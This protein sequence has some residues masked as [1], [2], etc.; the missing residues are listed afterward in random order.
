MTD[1]FAIL[2]GGLRGIS[3]ESYCRHRCL[4]TNIGGLIE[5]DHKPLFIGV[6]AQHEV[7]LIL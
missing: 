7:R 1:A 2:Y 3:R 5:E 4:T 6:E